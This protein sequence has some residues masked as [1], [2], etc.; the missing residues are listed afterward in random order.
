[1]SGSYAAPPLPERINGD[2]EFM[3][4]GQPELGLQGGVGAVPPQ[5]HHAES[6]QHGG[7][8]LAD[9]YGRVWWAGESWKIPGLYFGGFLW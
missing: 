4:Q 6:W 9:V 8:V 7:R 5:R 1:M 3:C 2:D